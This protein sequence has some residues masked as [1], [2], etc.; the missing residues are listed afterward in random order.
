MGVGSVSVIRA[1]T[2]ARKNDR[3]CRALSG[4]EEG[5]ASENLPPRRVRVSV[6]P[7]G[8]IFVHKEG[9]GRPG[10]K[11]PFP[12]REGLMQELLSAEQEAQA[13]QL[14]AHISEAIP[15]DGLALPRLLVS[16]TAKH[17]FGHPALP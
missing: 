14:A 13:P 16:R 12:I 15:L 8:G 4:K 11:S 1:L 6:S 17:T 3:S 9:V 2:A 10:Q 7:V 5:R